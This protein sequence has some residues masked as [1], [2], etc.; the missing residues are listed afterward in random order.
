MLTERVPYCIATNKISRMAKAW[1]IITNATM[2]L[3]WAHVLLLMIFNADAI[4]KDPIACSDS[5]LSI[6]LYRALA[7]SFIEVFN[8]I[9]GVIRSKPQFTLLFAVI[10]F[11]VEM[12]VAPMLGS[13]SAW[14]HLLTVACW[15]LGDTIR[16]ACFL[17]DNLTEGLL[18]KSVR[19]TVG[20]MLFPL[21][22]LGEMLMVIAA[23]N[24]QD[25]DTAR[26]AM[27]GAACLWPAGFYPLMK[28]LLRQ[29]RK[30]FATSNDKKKS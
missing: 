16:F 13:C 5:I 28:S 26:Y 17:L 24:K 12:I 10:R 19:Y 4:R 25:N 14:Q 15:S 7:L 18:A 2:T 20:P 1:I 11:G 8:A 27:Y 3:G 30:F 21:G 22:T 29:R 9:I 23:A 6:P